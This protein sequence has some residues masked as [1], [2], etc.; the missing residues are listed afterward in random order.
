MK[1]NLILSF[2]MF[3]CIIYAISCC[4]R[5]LLV[6]LLPIKLPLQKSLRNATS[7]FKHWDLSEFSAGNIGLFKRC[8]LVLSCF[9]QLPRLSAELEHVL[10]SP[11][12]AISTASLESALLLSSAGSASPRATTSTTAAVDSSGATMRPVRGSSAVIAPQSFAYSPTLSALVLFAVVEAAA[13][14]AVLATPLL[15]ALLEST[16]PFEI[17]YAS[18]SGGRY[19]IFAPLHCALQLLGAYLQL[20]ALYFAG[21]YLQSSRTV[22]LELRRVSATGPCSGSSGSKDTADAA[23][24]KSGVFTSV[25]GEARRLLLSR[26]YAILDCDAR[27]LCADPLS[28]VGAADADA[29]ASG[30]APTPVP[31]N[32][33]STGKGAK[34]QSPR[35]TT[36]RSASSSS[37]DAPAGT[38]P[39]RSSGGVDPRPQS[40][41]Q[42]LCC[43]VVL[44][45]AAL[46]LLAAISGCADQVSTAVFERLLLHLLL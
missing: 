44:G 31:G 11:P 13:L 23:V 45:V 41:M 33:S 10:H 7:L 8:V 46:Q 30:A 29:F 17:T 6:A 25:V 5:L 28:G 32:S 3:R 35:G 19:R 39:Y 37:G 42:N 12:P 18:V 34:Q 26:V 9:V 24:R 15:L 22:A 38:Q 2:N 16:H 21:A 1:T 20:T 27:T 40:C 4:N 43:L 14:T 36:Q